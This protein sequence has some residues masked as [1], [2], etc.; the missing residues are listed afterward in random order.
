MDAAL[1]TDQQPRLL[2]LSARA[3]DVSGT[4]GE[5]GSRGAQHPSLPH[6]S[7]P[8]VLTA[9]PAHV[10]GHPRHHRG[11]P[12]PGNGPRRGAGGHP[13]LTR[14]DQV[15]GITPHH[16]RTHARAVHG[17]RHRADHLRAPL[18]TARHVW[19]CTQPLDAAGPHRRELRGA[20]GGPGGALGEEET[21]RR[22]QSSHHRHEDHPDATPAP[23][24]AGTRCG[25][26]RVQ[27]SGT[28]GGSPE[29]KGS[30]TGTRP[31]SAGQPGAA[32]HAVD[33]GPVTGSSSPRPSPSQ[34]TAL[35]RPVRPRGAH[36]VCFR[37]SV[38][39]VGEGQGSKCYESL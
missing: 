29:A 20:R 18:R 10:G 19:V 34:A 8:A 9:P 39:R 21:E 12:T 23:T 35:R 30:L 25:H 13:P 4:R 7:A 5:S 33:P 16:L 3:A 28:R 11:A 1:T 14:G 15:V 27:C 17:L 26:H 24:P 37:A 22:T 31:P 2:G 36:T 32:H 6:R 38:R